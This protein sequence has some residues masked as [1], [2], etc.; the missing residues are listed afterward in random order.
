MNSKELNIN[1]ILKVEQLPKVYEDLEKIGIYLDNQLKGIDDIECTEKNKQDVKEK[2]ALVNNTLTVLENKRK[3]IKNII[4]KPYNCIEEKFN[5]NIK[6]KIINALEILDKKIVFIEDK[7]KENIKEQCE[8]YFCEYALSKNIDFVTFDNL[9]LKI[10][11]GLA[12]EK[13]ALTK[14]TKDTITEYIDKRVDDIKLIKMQKY[15]DEIL[16]DYKKHL[17]VTKAITEVTDR[18]KELDKIKEEKETKEEQKLNDEAMLNK[19][20]EVLKA[21][22]IVDSNVGQ[23]NGPQNGQA[24][25]LV[26]ATFKTTCLLSKMKKLVNFMVEE[27]I[28]YEQCK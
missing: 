23:E 5:N 13:G 2:R 19:I 1:E 3:E 15:Y 27:G 26:T 24:D 21:P 17:D 18:H 28:D 14:K 9:N 7:Q 11:L 16:V 22:K 6:D 4:L 25:E 10:T 8:S 12:T 20:D